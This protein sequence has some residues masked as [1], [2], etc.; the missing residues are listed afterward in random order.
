MFI[1]IGEWVSIVNPITF[2][3][4]TVQRLLNNGGYAIISAGRNPAIPSDVILSDA[5]IEQRTANLTAD[6]TNIFLYSAILGVYDGSS[7]TSFFITLHNQSPDQ[8]RAA[9]MILGEKYN[10][11]SIIYV[12]RKTPTIQQLIYTTGQFKGKYVQGQGYDEL[13]GNVTDNYSRLQICSNT[14]Y[15]FTL[16]FNFETM[17]AGRVAIQTRQLIDHHANNRMINQK[18]LNY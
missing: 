3:L 2:S 4:T 6:L 14:S 10:Q 1:F 11:D 16:N 12:R 18:R 8:E 7:E 5:I 15:T 17:I 9:V 13:L